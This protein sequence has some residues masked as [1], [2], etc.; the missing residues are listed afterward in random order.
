[1][2]RRRWCNGI[3]LV[4]T[5]NVDVINDDVDDVDVALRSGD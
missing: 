3:G 1:M 5:V 2:V 4:V